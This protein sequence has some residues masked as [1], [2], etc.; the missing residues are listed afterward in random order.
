MD[1]VVAAAVTPGQHVHL[2]ANELDLLDR[3]RRCTEALKALS[4]PELEALPATSSTPPTASDTA[5]LFS[6]ASTVLH[7]SSHL[8]DLPDRFFEHSKNEMDGHDSTGNEFPSEPDSTT[9]A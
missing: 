8:A 9:I 2:T 3:L 5:S 6:P 4:E 7:E 1:R